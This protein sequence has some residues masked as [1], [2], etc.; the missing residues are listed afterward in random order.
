MLLI[1]LCQQ[2]SLPILGIDAFEICG[3]KIQP[4]IE[5]SIDLSFEK[6]STLIGFI[7]FLYIFDFSFDFYSCYRTFFV[8]S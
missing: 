8:S 5:N 1:K 6:E 7:I 3:E 2:E 4:S